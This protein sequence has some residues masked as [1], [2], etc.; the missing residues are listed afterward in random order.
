MRSSMRGERE[1]LQILPHWYLWSIRANSAY[2]LLAQATLI[3][4]EAGSEPR[5]RDRI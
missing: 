2:I 5:D 4:A 1:V 3:H